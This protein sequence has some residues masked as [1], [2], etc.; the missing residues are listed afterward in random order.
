MAKNRAV[1]NK[2]DVY[3]DFVKWYRENVPN[4][5]IESIF[6]E[7]L[8]YATYYNKLYKVDI[9]QLPKELKES[10]TEF[11]YISSDMPA[12]MLMELCSINSKTNAQ[13]KPLITLAQ[14]AEVVELINTYLM[15]RALC[16]LDTSDISRYFPVVLKDT[17]E[18]C[19]GNYAMLVD[20][21]KRNLAI[22]NFVLKLLGVA[23][24]L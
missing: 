3:N 2:T 22:P 17:L 1:V 23:I 4:Y 7:I 12:P 11:R 13:G 18:A 20:V 15:R 9:A 16:G 10:I 8:N 24:L 6:I 5:G 14:I 21:V 19:N